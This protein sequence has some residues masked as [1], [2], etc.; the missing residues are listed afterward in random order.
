MG[1]GERGQGGHEITSDLMFKMAVGG[2][3]KI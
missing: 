3:G 2:I 1:G